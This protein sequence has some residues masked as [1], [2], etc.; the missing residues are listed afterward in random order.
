[1][2]HKYTDGRPGKQGAGNLYKG[3]ILRKRAKVTKRTQFIIRKTNS[4]YL[5]TVAGREISVVS[6]NRSGFVS[7]SMT[8]ASTL[9]NLGTTKLLLHRPADP[10]QYLK[11]FYQIKGW[12]IEEV[13]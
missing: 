5:V 9:Q 6:L 1:L 8:I 10:L 13:V 11:D 12:L 2:S 4:S 7:V 3:L